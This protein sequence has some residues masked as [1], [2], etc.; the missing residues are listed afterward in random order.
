LKPPANWDD[1]AQAGKELRHP[2]KHKEVIV[3]LRPD[4]FAS[5]GSLLGLQSGFVYRR[6][7]E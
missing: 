2:A 4:A 7:I 1:E 3:H 5:P 6:S